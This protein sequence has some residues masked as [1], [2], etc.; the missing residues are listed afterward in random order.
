MKRVVAVSACEFFNKWP[1]SSYIYDYEDYHIKCDIVSRDLCVFNDKYTLK[2]E[3]EPKDIQ[4][5]LDY[6]ECEGFKIKSSR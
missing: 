1:S 2:L 3:G 4:L 5:F 6:L